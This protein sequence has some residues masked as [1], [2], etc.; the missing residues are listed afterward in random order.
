MRRLVLVPLAACASA[1][2]APSVAPPV[3]TPADLV[4]TL[5]RPGEL[6]LLVADRG[7]ATCERW[8]VDPAQ[9]RLVRDEG[10]PA[11]PVTHELD[12]RVTGRQLAV[13]W[14]SRTYANGDA[15]SS[16]CDARVEVRELPDALDVGGA[17]WF[18]TAAGC[19][20]ARAHHARVAIAPDLG[21]T[22]PATPGDRAHEASRARFER[23]LARGGTLFAIDGARC[24]PVR[25]VPARDP[26]RRDTLEGE[27]DSPV[28][29]DQGMHGTTTYNYELARGSDQL[30]L[31]GPSTTWSDGSSDA[32]G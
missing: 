8:Q 25:V 16:E 32:F 11:A 4:P 9:H 31:L 23:V 10:T 21:C 28:V 14:A 17:R 3:A 18:R 26:D 1:Q 24:S 19:E 27:L 29:D 20:D 22:L 5:S 2:A 12:F 6:F 15:G 30:T 13:E 7:R